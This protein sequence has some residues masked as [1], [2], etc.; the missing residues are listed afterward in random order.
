LSLNMLEDDFIN[1]KKN[2]ATLIN[3]GLPAF[4]SSTSAGPVEI[5]EGASINAE[6]GGN[7]LVFSPNIINSGNIKTESG[8]TILASTQ[9]KVY[10]TPSTD[11]ALRGFLVEVGTGGSVENLGH[12]LSERGNITLA[13]LAINQ[14]GVLEATSS[15]NENG[16]IRLLARDG[17]EMTARNS[18]MEKTDGS[19]LILGIDINKAKDAD[20]QSILNDEYAVARHTG[21]ITLGE[22][23]QIVIKPVEVL[24]AA[25]KDDANDVVTL[26]DTQEQMKSRVEITGNVIRMQENSEIVVTS[27]DVVIHATSNTLNTAVTEHGVLHTRDDS[28][29]VMQSG[30]RIDVSGTTTAEVAMQRNQLEVQLTGNFLRD[31]PLQS[32]GKLRNER[33]NVDIRDGT[34][35]GDISEMIAGELQRGAVSRFATGG[36]GNVVS[37]GGVWLANNS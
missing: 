5:K 27:G 12:I 28:K 31:A 26:T 29:F 20:D 3:D 22:A 9:D 37:E 19:N 11:P 17:A 14:A 4:V 13:G 34:P 23:S 35:L 8:Q 24:N 21:E 6:N 2:I 7:I 36:S 10:L 18:Q 33:V 15:V 16:S 25:T 1:S 32:D 30:S